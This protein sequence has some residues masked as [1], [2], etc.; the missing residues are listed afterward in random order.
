MT[1]ARSSESA[2][3]CSLSQADLSSRQQRWLRLGEHAHTGTMTTRNGLR[4]SF[5]NEPATEHEL[6]ELIALERHCCAFAH[7]SLHSHGDILALDV[8]ADS[9]DG[10][11]AVQAMFRTLQ[12]AP[13]Q[14]SR[15]DSSDRCSTG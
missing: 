2:V 1:A 8:T 10:I 11:A 4:L 3:A 7:W 13:P 12:P 9:V 5:R 6:N 15:S 14:S